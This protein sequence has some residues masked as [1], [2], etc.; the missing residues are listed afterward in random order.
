MSNDQLIYE[1]AKIAI[2]LAFNNRKTI[3]EKL[4]ST[5]RNINKN[6]LSAKASV[7]LTMYADFKT[8]Y[9]IEMV[10]HYLC[11]VLAKYKI[12]G[13][14]HTYKYGETQF[15]IY[16][17]FNYSDR[18]YAPKED[19][20]FDTTE[21]EDEIIMMPSVN[22]ISIYLMPEDG[23]TKTQLLD[24]H[25]LTEFLQCELLHKFDVKSTKAFIYVEGETSEDLG[26]I[27][28]VLQEKIQEWDGNVRDLSFKQKELKL[29]AD[30]LTARILGEIL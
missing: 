22:G 1:G 28:Q 9:A 4:K 18:F 26:K 21:S 5:W 30:P 27:K 25:K 6:G 24:G 19:L 14:E 13:K 23:S 3:Y 11:Q 17:E 15:A 16:P 10:D 20:D 2:P 7:Y 12:Q 29:R 8:D